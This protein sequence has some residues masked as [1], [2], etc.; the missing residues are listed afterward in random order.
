MKNENQV[1]NL[2]K[3]ARFY[4]EILA[5][6]NNV[7]LFKKDLCGYCGVG[8]FFLKRLGKF[9]NLDFD[10]VC[11]TYSSTNHYSGH[12]WVE[13]DNHVIDITGTQFYKDIINPV[14]IVKKN[15]KYNSKRTN[16]SALH[17][18]SK[19]WPIEQQYQTYEK[20]LNTI[21][22]VAGKYLIST[23]RKQN[24]KTSRSNS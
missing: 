7:D 23:E 19:Y 3:Q 11:G 9:I 4:L 22:V 2:A 6:Q 16:E 24:A 14:H 12:C 15:K 1:I 13:F 10:F 21:A 18:M 8:S 17:Y 5:L 20:D